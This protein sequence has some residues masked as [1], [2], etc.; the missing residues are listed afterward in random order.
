MT[1]RNRVLHALALCLSLIAIANQATARLGLPG[2]V[3]HR[4]G[5][6]IFT[7][8]ICTGHGWKTVQID[9]DGRPLDE[10]P[11]ARGPK[12][13]CPICT[14]LQTASACTLAPVIGLS[15]PLNSGR[16]VPAKPPQIRPVSRPYSSYVSRAPPASR[17]A[18]PA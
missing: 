8:V 16:V 13:K 15:A 7:I 17:F 10:V 4:A 12:T 18:M 3:P 14:E 6:D 2:I 5:S 9:K 11:A 1:G